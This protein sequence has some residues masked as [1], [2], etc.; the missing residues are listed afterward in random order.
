MTI[1]LCIVS[2]L[3]GGFVGAILQSY[4]HSYFNQPGDI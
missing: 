1:V 3:V 4:A 2:F